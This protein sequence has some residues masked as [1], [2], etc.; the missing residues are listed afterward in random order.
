MRPGPTKLTSIIQNGFSCEA[1]VKCKKR[2]RLSNAFYRERSKKSW[3][4]RKK[5]A[6]VRA[7]AEAGKMEEAA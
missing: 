4:T 6:A 2:K 1:P 3:E 5:Q 7:Q